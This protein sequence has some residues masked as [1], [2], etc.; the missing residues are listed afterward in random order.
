MR[1]G[2]SQATTLPLQVIMEE[3]VVTKNSPLSCAVKVDLKW[4]KVFIREKLMTI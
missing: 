4:S 2:V 1:A 3:R